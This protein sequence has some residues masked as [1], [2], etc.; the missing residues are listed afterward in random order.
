MANAKIAKND[1]N[2]NYD[3]LKSEH[4]FANDLELD[5]LFTELANVASQ[6]A[7]KELRKHYN[8]KNVFYKLSFANKKICD[9]FKRECLKRVSND[10][11]RANIT[12]MFRHNYI[13]NNC[14][15]NS[16]VIDLILKIADKQNDVYDVV[17]KFDF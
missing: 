7:K 3:K 2:D 13:N 4:D 8:D 15:L 12:E 1:I 16:R 14:D 17:S 11:L 9:F 5:K 10:N 6:K